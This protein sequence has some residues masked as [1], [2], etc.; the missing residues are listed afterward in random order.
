VRE[1]A[2]VTA[3][4]V[5]DGELLMVRQA[6]PGEEPVWTIPGGRVEAGEFVTDALI[7]ETREEAGIAV[8]DPGA[9]AFLAQV[10]DQDAGWFATVWTWHVAAWEGEVAV[11][12]PD[13]F[14]LEAGWVPL[15]EAC[16]RLSRISW[17]VVTARYLRGE[18]PPGSLWLQRGRPGGKVIGPLGLPRSR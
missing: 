2:I 1:L 13:G 3:L 11:D 10:E 8:L 17:H 12:D 6:G 5:R 9:I 15:S 16:D 4:V 14:V 18:V 7:R